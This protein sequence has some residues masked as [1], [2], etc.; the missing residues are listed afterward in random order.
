MDQSM[1]ERCTNYFVH[2]GPTEW[3]GG[4]LTVAFLLLTTFTKINI[5]G[6]L[7]AIARQIMGLK[8]Q[9]NGRLRRL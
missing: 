5:P 1:L 6:L 8:S 9:R 3:I 7:W 4:G 2:G